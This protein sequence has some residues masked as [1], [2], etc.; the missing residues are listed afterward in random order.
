MLM[1]GAAQGGRRVGDYPSREHVERPSCAL[2]A[3]MKLDSQTVL[4]LLACVAPLCAACLADLR[5][6]QSFA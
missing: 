1:L 4:R 2:V 6:G 5:A 3:R